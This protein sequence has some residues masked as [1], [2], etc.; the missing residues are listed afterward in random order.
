M[1]TFKDSQA[2]YKA[3]NENAYDILFGFV[4]F[5]TFKKNMMDFKKNTT[6]EQRLGKAPAA[7]GNESLLTGMT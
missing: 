7:E 6:E 3:A 4:D 1:D 5:D 2:E